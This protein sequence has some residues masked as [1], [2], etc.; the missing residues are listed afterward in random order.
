[1]LDLEPNSGGFVWIFLSFVIPITVVLSILLVKNDMLKFELITFALI[2][3][4]IVFLAKGN[5][6]PLPE[7][8]PHLYDIPL[9]GWMFQASEFC[10]RILA[11]L[12][13]NDYHNRNL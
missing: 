11:F 3:L 6:E 9:V 1:M 2:S 10:C 8:Y 7:L 4:F 5:Q 13:W 12:L